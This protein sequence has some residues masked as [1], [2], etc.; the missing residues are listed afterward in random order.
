MRSSQLLAAA[1]DALHF[2]KLVD[3]VWRDMRRIG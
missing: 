3:R 2:P 1:L